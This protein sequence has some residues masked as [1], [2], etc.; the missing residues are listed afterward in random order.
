LGKRDP[1]FRN[2]ALGIDAR[3]RQP[4]RVKVRFALVIVAAEVLVEPDTR[5]GHTKSRRGAAIEVGVQVHAKV[6]RLVAFVAPAHR[7]LDRR[8][9]KHAGSNV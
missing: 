4:H 8:A 6:F 9:R 2:P 5:C 1:E 7:R 3:A